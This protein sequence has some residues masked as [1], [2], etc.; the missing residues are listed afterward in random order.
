[1]SREYTL[2]QKDAIYKNGGNILVSAAAGSGKTA[3][4][5]ERIIQKITDKDNPVDIDDFLIV[6]FTKAAAG[7][8][9]ERIYKAIENCC[10]TEPDNENYQRQLVLCNKAK[11]T[12]ID[13]FCYDITKKY[14]Y[15]LGVPYDSN[16]G[17]DSKINIIKNNC[18]ND[19]IE[20]YY[21]KIDDVEFLNLIKLFCDEKNDD[22][23]FDV[24]LH[25]YDFISKQPFPDKWLKDNLILYQKAYEKPFETK[26]FK[27]IV[28]EFSIKLDYFFEKYKKCVSL[29]E[30][31]EE[32]KNYKK[33]IIEDFEY[34]MILKDAI[35]EK[36][37]KKV[38]YLLKNIPSGP[39]GRIMGFSGIEKDFCS[40]TRSDFIAMLKESSTL[41]DVD[42]EKFLKSLKEHIPLIIKLN[43][44]LEKLD[45]HIF[46]SCIEEKIFSYN[47]IER[48]AVK[49]LVKSYDYD[50]DKLEK[51]DI[52]KEL[53]M[54]FEEIFIDEFQDINLIQE[55]IFRAVSRDNNMY[56]VGDMKQSIYRFRQAMPEIFSSKK[57]TYNDVST[58]QFP[59]LIRLNKN[60]RS[61]ENILD[62]SNFIF[63][64]LF[65]EYAGELKYDSS[66]M[67]YPGKKEYAE[68]VPVNV[69]LIDD[70]KDYE[71]SEITSISSVK[72]E[73]IYIADKIQEIVKNDS[74]INDD[75]VK[76]AIKY[77]DIAVLYRSKTGIA[78]ALIE[79]FKARN[80]P[81]ISE[82]KVEYLTCYE[83][84]SFVS[85]LKIIDN[86]LDDIAVISA[87]RSPIFSFSFDELLEIRN[88]D[89]NEKFYFLLEKSENKKAKYFISK[90]NEYRELSRNVTVDILI[91]KI[92]NDFDAVSLYEAVKIKQGALKG[93]TSRENLQMLY[94]YAVSFENGGYKGLTAFIK[95]IDDIIKNKGDLA[96]GKKVYHSRDAVNLITIHKSKGLEYPV[97]FICGL[98]KSFNKTDFKNNL[99]LNSSLGMGF[100]F[101][102]FEYNSFF[103]N[104]IR[105]SIYSK[106]YKEFYSEELRVLYVALTRPK[107]R[108]YLVIHNK[109]SDKNDLGSIFL[110]KS[111]EI[112]E[113]GEISPF[114]IMNCSSFSD[115]L[116]MA[117]LRHHDFKK[118]REESGINLLPIEQKGN[119]NFE[120]IKNDY[121]EKYVEGI[122]NNEEIIEKETY[123]DEKDIEEKLSFHYDKNYLSKIPA[124]LSVSELKGRK[125]LKTPGD[126]EI[127]YNVS[128]KKPYFATKDKV[129]AADKGIAFHKFMQYLDYKN[130]N[131]ENIDG[132]IDNLVEKGFLLEEEKNLLDMTKINKYLESPLFN[133]LRNSLKIIREYRFNMEVPINEYNEI[134]TDDE[135][136]ILVQGV[137][138]CIFQDE[139]GDFF[140]LDYKTDKALKN[141]LL[142]RYK[143]QL[144]LYEKAVNQIFKI[145][146]KSRIIYGLYENSE[147]YF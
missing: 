141:E 84:A 18:L 73:A 88:N 86:P 46:K 139:N 75:K 134:I 28:S 60:F 36:E 8:M 26:W 16:I 89:R 103:N 99:L 6:T 143:K 111:F 3:V 23:I 57:N 70:N 96:G 69:C 142:N 112:Q 72:K 113:N 124:K 91:S 71:N 120:V 32:L 109:T 33:K 116:L 35:S 92:I 101:R 81:Y 58:G 29:V 47:D 129:S 63:K 140:V 5:V 51:T 12:T 4:L 11:I 25:I 50:S 17:D 7:E 98:S 24:I 131:Q 31:I 19:I 126:K 90:V 108:L 67:L 80:I 79:E 21:N 85:F 74:I 87:L 66:E 65:S 64:Q 147:I 146:V 107:N 1:M 10:K 53:S 48:I 45:E 137:I 110:K 42:D 106:I 77:S 54:D 14:G 59:C 22:K 138:D 97:C 76:T 121:F 144:E 115:M 13:S 127:E 119:A 135:N 37:Y 93:D 118:L 100:K 20:E 30:E 2:Q 104:Y 145:N 56:M 52:A 128:F 27:Q 95:Y 62:F 133:K 78:D 114:S 15:C 38:Q 117:M 55:L 130:V 43:E 9:R 68:N 125:Y 34:I 49:T 132:F 94:N 40:S 41:F 44:I 122:E 102:D 82:E 39:I 61:E 105:K 123:F 136:K 83:I